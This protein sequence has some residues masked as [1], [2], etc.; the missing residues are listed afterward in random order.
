MRVAG[1]AFDR[2][3]AGSAVVAGPPL[4]AQGPAPP[5]E[6][7]VRTLLT[8]G[9]ARAAV[10]AAWRAVG[11]APDDARVESMIHRARMAAL[12]PETLLRAMRIVD[13]RA[14]EDVYST[15]A[16]RAYGSSGT[17]LRLEARLTWR[18]DRL[19]F[20]DDEPSLE[21]I[22]MDH[23]EA[24]MRL[25]SKVLD[26]LFQW[27]R[28]WL[29]ADSS[30]RGTREEFDAVLKAVEAEAVLDVLTAGWFATWRATRGPRAS[31]A[32]R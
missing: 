26:S 6:L 1:F 13:D 23:H 4:Y 9:L 27:Q 18:L 24:R 29:D 28:A 15:D 14:S 8:P 22:R 32:G 2:L 10:Q 12:L 25:A 7:P 17:G 31:P 30:G 3:A 5:I 20:A 11:L 19:V 21:R 16:A